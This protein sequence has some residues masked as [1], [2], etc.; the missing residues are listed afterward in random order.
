MRSRTALVVA[1][2]CA[3]AAACTASHDN[4]PDLTRS[5]AP[6]TTA[7][8]ATTAAPTPAPTEFGTKDS[9]I[10]RCVSAE[11]HISPVPT[12]QPSTHDV[13]VGPL[14]WPGLKDR[15]H[16]DLEGFAAQQSDGWHYKIG[17]EIAAGASVTV[18]VAPQ[19][20]TKAGLEYGQQ[21]DYSS[22]QEVAFH[23]CP[24]GR[25]AYVGGFFVAGPTGRICLPL[26]IR[27]GE[28]PPRRITVSLGAGPCPD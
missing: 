20:R 19:A 26:D 4:R 1:T 27:T 10:V 25:T 15:A 2:A 17:A 23:A 18:S 8:P 24:K 5:A 9:R 28:A 7:A 22:A 16:S 14:R 13:V 6:T 12:R 21:W 11:A 3:L